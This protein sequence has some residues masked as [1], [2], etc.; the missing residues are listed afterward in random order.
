MLGASMKTYLKWGGAMAGASFL[1]VIVVYLLGL[2]SDPTKLGTGQAIQMVLGLAVGIAC[3]VLGTK[4]LRATVP[5]AEEFSYGRALGAGVMI[6][7]FAAA[8]GIISNLLY[9]Q[10]INPGMT[11][12]AVQAQIAKWESMGMSG[13]QIERAEGMMRTMMSPALSMVFGFLGGMLFG[14]II[15]L[16]SAAFLKRPASE[17]FEPPVVS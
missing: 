16:I 8:F 6:T 4:E 10:F 7:L 2:H 12:V 1:V 14:T 9:M 3:I 17:E 11:E 13:A 15:S 5:P